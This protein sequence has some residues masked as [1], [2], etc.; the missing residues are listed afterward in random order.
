M[1]LEN[2]LDKIEDEALKPL[3]DE[4]DGKFELKE[5]YRSTDPSTELTNALDRTKIERNELKDKVKAFDD[6][7][8]EQAIKLAEATGNKEEIERL[9][10]IKLDKQKSV[11]EQELKDAQALNHELTIG[12]T[13][14]GI[15]SEVYLKGDAWKMT[16]MESRIKL[17]EDGKTTFLVNKL[18]ETVTREVFIAELRSDE[19]MSFAI[20]G[21]QASGGGKT[22]TKTTTVNSKDDFTKLN[23]EQ[24]RFQLQSK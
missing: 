9:T 19:S 13:R 2:T 5:A 20:R 15:A 7:K 8:D 16:D 24:A 21:S 18:G 23:K 22:E 1:S 11:H 14:D 3:Y 10:Q 12:M 6:Y 17:S 4:K